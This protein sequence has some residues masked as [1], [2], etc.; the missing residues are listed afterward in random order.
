MY[1]V[2]EIPLVFLVLAGLTKH[3]QNPSKENSQIHLICP[4]LEILVWAVL[5]LKAE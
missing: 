4:D 5:A 1:S 3:V 2:G